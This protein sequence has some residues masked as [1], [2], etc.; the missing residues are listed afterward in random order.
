MFPSYDDV[1]VWLRTESW[2]TI[3]LA[4]SWRA[5]T[6]LKCFFLN[7]KINFLKVLKKEMYKRA[8]INKLRSATDRYDYVI[9]DV[10]RSFAEAQLQLWNRQIKGMMK[11]YDRPVIRAVRTRVKNPENEI[12]SKVALKSNHQN[13]NS[14]W[15]LHLGLSFSRMGRFSNNGSIDIFWKAAI[16][17]IF[18]LQTFM[19]FV[20]AKL[21]LKSLNSGKSLKISEFFWQKMSLKIFYGV[22]SRNGL[23]V[24]ISISFSIS[25]YFENLVIWWWAFINDIYCLK[26]NVSGSAW[27]YKFRKTFWK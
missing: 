13:S 10:I 9:N 6:I 27:G 7:P 23:A 1:I 25:N 19:A 15:T 3:C 18:L 2:R 8:I 20:L 17:E 26:I 5:K 4:K 21:S 22:S 14:G 11:G 24:W 12:R 16:F